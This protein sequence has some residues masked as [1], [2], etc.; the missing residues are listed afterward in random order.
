MYFKEQLKDQIDN[1]DYLKLVEEKARAAWEK[2]NYFT[3][4]SNIYS[5]LSL[6]MKLNLLGLDYVKDGKK[7]NLHLIKER[8]GIHNNNY[9]SYFELNKRN[10]LIAQ[11][12]ARWNAYHLVSEFM[13]LRKDEIEMSLNEDKVKFATKNL[14]TKRHA[15]LTTYYG[16]DELSSYLAS[17]ASKALNKPVSKEEYDLYIYD[18]ALIESSVEVLQELGYSVREK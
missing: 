1:P 7:E 18:C 11:E 8:Y 5:A 3:L 13:P 4:Y 16:L 14:L 10:A 6:R 15:C 9:D 17:E 12:H 2:Q